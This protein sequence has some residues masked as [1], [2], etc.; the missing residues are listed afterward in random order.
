ME[1]ESCGDVSVNKNA[2]RYFV[3]EASMSLHICKVVCAPI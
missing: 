2:F 1:H 3:D